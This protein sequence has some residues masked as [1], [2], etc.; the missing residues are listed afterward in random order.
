MLTETPVV[1][2]L[3]FR[4]PVL[5]LV[6]AL[7]FWTPRR[8][9]AIQGVHE[10]TSGEGKLGRTIG[11]EGELNVEVW[12]CTVFR[13]SGDTNAELVGLRCLM[14]TAESG[15]LGVSVPDTRL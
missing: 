1:Q 14:F 13:C 4:A 15:T 6:A 7:A 2:A 3:R 5:R 11:S 10:G 9:M 8:Q 12:Q